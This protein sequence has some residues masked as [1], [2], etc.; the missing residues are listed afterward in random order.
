MYTLLTIYYK[1]RL[2]THQ[3]FH[4]IKKKQNIKILYYFVYFGL[5]NKLCNYNRKQRK[6]IL[7]IILRQNHHGFAQVTI[8]NV[9]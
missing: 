1:S 5:W 7:N 4:E 6:H 3:N 8:N 9:V 2:S